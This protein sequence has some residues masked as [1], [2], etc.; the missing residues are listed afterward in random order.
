MIYYYIIADFY[1]DLS[2]ADE[3]EEALIPYHTYEEAC[4]A[5]EKTMELYENNNELGCY[6]TFWLPDTRS[7]VAFITINDNG[8]YRAFRFEIAEGNLN[9]LK[10]K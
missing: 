8:V 10:V 9:I 1:E 7:T 5:I 4:D 6:Q 3:Y 2:K